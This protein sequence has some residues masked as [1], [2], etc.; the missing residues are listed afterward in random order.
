MQNQNAMQMVKENGWDVFSI[1]S[2]LMKA[3]GANNQTYK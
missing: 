3:S 1:S 2:Q